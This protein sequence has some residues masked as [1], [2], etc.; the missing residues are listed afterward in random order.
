MADARSYDPP[1]DPVATVVVDGLDSIDDAGPD[2]TLTDAGYEGPDAV[3]SGHLA[4]ATAVGGAVRIQTADVD[5]LA[6]PPWLVLAP[7]G[8]FVATVA[9]GTATVTVTCPLPTRRLPATQERLEA[10][11]AAARARH[12]HYPVEADDEGVFRTG[13]TQFQFSLAEVTAD[14]TLTVRFDV[15]T[16]PATTTSAIVDR[17]AALDFDVTTAVDFEQGVE[18]ASPSSALRGAVE[19]AHRTVIGDA[20]YEWLSRPTVFSR[21]PSAE[22]IAFGVGTGTTFSH[23]AFTQTRDLLE[24]TLEA[25]AG[26]G[27]S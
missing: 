27:G 2:A 21:V 9:T 18:R 3:A 1:D 17:F 22:K 13:M 10:V 20:Q 5:L 4:A 11:L 23:E 6:P 12:D 25:L 19:D 7:L 15:S 16:T 24:R 8:G 26:G 14:D